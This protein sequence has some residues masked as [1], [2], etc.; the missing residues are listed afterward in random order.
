MALVAFVFTFEF[1]LV[2]SNDC[3]QWREEGELIAWLKT[4]S[5][6][7]GISPHLQIKYKN[8]KC[9]RQRRRRMDLFWKLILISTLSSCSR[10]AGKKIEDHLLS[11]KKNA[12]KRLKYL[13]HQTKWSRLT[14]F[15]VMI[16]FGENRLAPETRGKFKLWYISF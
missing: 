6:R 11:K 13:E 7:C 5:V 4:V 8:Q 10:V 12:R 2:P 14:S 16:Q 3:P 9:F 1:V 15:Q